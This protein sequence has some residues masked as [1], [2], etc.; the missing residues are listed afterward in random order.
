MKRTKYTKVLEI[1]SEAYFL[2][3]DALITSC[4]SWFSFLFPMIALWPPECSTLLTRT[5]RNQ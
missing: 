5:R 2:V 3:S 4:P 1:E